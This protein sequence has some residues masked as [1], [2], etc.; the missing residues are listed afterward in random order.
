MYP[1][2][3]SE[4]FEWRF[5][6]DGERGLRRLAKGF[7]TFIRLH[8]VSKAVESSCKSKWWMV[9][10]GELQH[11]GGEKGRGQRRRDDFCPSAP[12]VSLNEH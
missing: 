4:D 6:V 5:V 1:S 2:Q 3:E 7:L 8:K 10:A 9:E 11:C 12:A